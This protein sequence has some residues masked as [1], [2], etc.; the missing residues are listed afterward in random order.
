MR[1]PSL[2]F[3]LCALGILVSSPASAQAPRIAVSASWN[4]VSGAFPRS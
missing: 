4:S 2:V 1:A 3:I